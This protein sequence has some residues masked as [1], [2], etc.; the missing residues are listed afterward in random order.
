MTEKNKKSKSRSIVG[1]EDGTA[2]DAFRR[3]VVASLSGPTM[4]QFSA[5]ASLLI[6]GRPGHDLRAPEPLIQV[7]YEPRKEEMGEIV[8][9]AKAAGRDLIHIGCHDDGS[10]K[11]TGMIAV[12]YFEDGKPRPHRRA[13]LVCAPSDTRVF[14]AGV[15]DEEDESCSFVLSPGKKMVRVAGDPLDDLGAGMSRGGKL[16]FECMETLDP[17]DCAGEA[18]RIPGVLQGPGGPT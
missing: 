6:A 18:L 16:W 5:A 1:S 10:G 4:K 12:V 15:S 13:S 11:P 9:M 3:I 2:Q 8:E 14:L 17:L 7:G